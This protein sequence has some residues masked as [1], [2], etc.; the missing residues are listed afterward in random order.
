M[1]ET[2][3]KK[4]NFS[5]VFSSEHRVKQG[6]QVRTLLI[7]YGLW[8]II[9][10]ILSVWDGYYLWAFYDEPVCMAPNTMSKRS[11]EYKDKWANVS[12]R[13]NAVLK[14]FFT[15]SVVDVFRATIM[16][17]ATLKKSE[18]LIHFY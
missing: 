16:I 7:N 2:P 1:S 14:I 12:E 11:T 6:K 8:L 10:I 9:S 4:I 13:Y 15:C 5:E 18:R 17:I 3:Q